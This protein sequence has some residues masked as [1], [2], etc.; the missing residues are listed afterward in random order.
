VVERLR[1]LRRFEHLPVPLNGWLGH[2]LP[3][4]TRSMHELADGEVNALE[5]APLLVAFSLL[6]SR[7]RISV[8]GSGGEIARAYYGSSLDVD[9]LV[10]KLGGATAPVRQALRTDLFPEPAAP[11]RSAVERFVHDSP[12]S[13]PGAVL[14]DFYLRA[15]MQRFAGRNITT[16]GLYC[17]QA[18]PFFENQVVDVSLSLPAARKRQGRVVRDALAA[19]APDLARVPL[20]SGIAVAPRSWRAPGAGA[21]WTAAMGRKAV[22]RYGGSA[23]RRLAGRSPEVVPW[24]AARSE[25]G[26]REFV[27]TTLP[28]EGSRVH[29]LL[30]PTATSRLV[31]AGLAGGSLYPLGL[32]LTLEMT[33]R[34][35]DVAAP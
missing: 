19:W 13:E 10:R 21:R 28:S 14:D 27:G 4:L 5:Y 12:A 32:V 9:A 17:R 18:L 23:G 8:S 35:L 20:D 7:R 30:E 33:L 16:T 3:D 31:E 34:R 1:E 26:F 24:A 15:R 2:A 29:R 25:A 11:L 6:D 22:A